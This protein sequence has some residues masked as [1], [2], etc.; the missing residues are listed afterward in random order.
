MSLHTPIVSVCIPVFNC[1]AFIESAITSVL[2]QTFQNFELIIIDDQST[3]HV[4]DVIR[5]LADSVN[6]DRLKVFRNDKNLGPEAN[7]N[8]C[9]SKAKGRFIKVMGGDDI[10]YPDCLE[11]Q[12][13][14]LSNPQYEDIAF[15]SGWRD[16]IDPRGNVLM[17]NRGMKNRRI[18]Q[19]DGRLRRDDAF[20][21]ILRSGT[22]PI[23][24]P[25]AVL[26]RSDLVQKTG[27]FS[28]RDI[29]YLIDLDQWCRFLQSGH[30]YVL[31]QTICAFR[32]S[33]TSW[34]YKLGNAQ[35]HQVRRFFLQL[36]R[37][38]QMHALFDLTLGICMAF[39][40]CRMRGWLY[41]FFRLREYYQNKQQ[42]TPSCI[43]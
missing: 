35:F 23:G 36:H 16:I 33:N 25:V 4:Y 32:V 34:S 20:R 14:I 41:F 10:L 9:L 8:F 30:L 26:F 7:W 37:E 38:H 11:L 29:P 1:E 19:G 2:Q 5:R 40:L 17:R 6:D 21:M 18:I 13:R 31:A 27:V 12:V 42:K 22:N 43:K 28:G 3:D 39:V 15:V 24:E